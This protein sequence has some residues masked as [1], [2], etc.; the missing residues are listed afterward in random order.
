M[1]MSHWVMGN[2]TGADSRS[3]ND[4][5]TFAL[6]ERIDAQQ[7]DALFKDG[8]AL[9]ERTATYLDGKGRAESK[10][11][12]PAITVLYATESMRLTARLLDVAS[13]LLI[14][15]ALREGEISESE[16]RSKRQRLK[17]QTLGRPSHTRGFDE[18]P[19]TLRTLIVE[20]FDML[21]RI[22]Q[23]DRAATQPL[24]IGDGTTA[25]PLNPV[26]AQVVRLR[27]AFARRKG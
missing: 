4:A 12:P 22:V 25:A 5:V 14:R 3:S 21:A 24:P 23:L 19:E 8:M 16:A 27:D 20:S 17:L 6:S 9:V 1:W 2:D 15:R 7:F 13:W 10:G 26:G 18:L 11:L